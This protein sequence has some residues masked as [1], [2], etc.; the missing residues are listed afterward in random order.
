MC[1]CTVL[2]LSGLY[3]YR[4][5]VANNHVFAAASLIYPLSYT[6]NNIVCE[7]YQYN[8]SRKLIWY[9]LICVF[10]F[11]F[12]VKFFNAMPYP[13]NW[14]LYD[15]YNNVLGSYIRLSM[16]GFG[17]M[18]VGEFMNVIVLSKCKTLFG[19]NHFIARC[20]GSTIIGSLLDVIIEYIIAFS[21]IASISII[22]EMASFA[23]FFRLIYAII[24]AFP[25]FVIVS[26]L[27]RVENI[28]HFQP[29][30]SYNP[31]RL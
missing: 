21:G 22:I 15:S 26:V 31:F 1:Y 29:A 14:N 9:G 10:L 28:D 16:A 12:I 17:S 3:V 8:N 18:V 20:L 27:K 11:A 6:I 4:P 2:I 23:L 30:I 24:L 25:A 5:I 19:G 13:T 7:V